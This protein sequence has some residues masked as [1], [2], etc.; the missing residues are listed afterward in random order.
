M[1]SIAGSDVVFENFVR[2]SYAVS[3]DGKRFLIF[4]PL[5]E[6]NA[7]PITIVLNWQA[8]PKK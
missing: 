3:S 6:G 2:R 8:V 4:K 1:F 5:R 7:A